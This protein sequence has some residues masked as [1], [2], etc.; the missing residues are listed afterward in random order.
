MEEYDLA[1]KE[2]IE[3]ISQIQDINTLKNFND[4]WE[5]VNNYI[6]NSKGIYKST[7]YKDLKTTGKRDFA[8]FI[9]EKLEIK[10]SE[11][12]G[13]GIFTKND[14]ESGELILLEKAFFLR[15]RQIKWN[16]TENAYSGSIWKDEKIARLIK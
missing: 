16:A 12:K 8:N 11:G 4:L 9:S 14:I 5:K 13:R 6:Q 10:M 7:F 15:Q 1:R 3:I 2:L